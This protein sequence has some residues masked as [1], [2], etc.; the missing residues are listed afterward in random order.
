MRASPLKRLWAIPLI[1]LPAITALWI[2]VATRDWEHGWRQFQLG[3]HVNFPPRAKPGPRPEAIQTAQH[4]AGAVLHIAELATFAIAVVALVVLASRAH[5]RARR[6]RAIERWELRLGRDD[7]ANPYRVQ[8]AFEGIA[9]AIGVRWYERLCRGPQH[10]A[11]EVHRLHDASIRFVIAAPDR[12]LAAISGALEDLY[13][14]V[15]LVGWDRWPEASRCVVRLKKRASF[16]LSIQTTR[17]YEHAFS[18]SLVALIDKGTGDLCVQLVLAPASGHLHRRAR[19]L[20]KR[21]ERSLQHADH[22]DPGE[23]GIDSVIEAKELKGALE[24]QHRTLYQFD[25]RVSGEDPAS[26]RRVAGLF[27]Q[28][29]SENELVRRQMRMRRS[30]YAARIA[31]AMPNALPG[32]RTGTLSTSELATLWQLPRGRVKH[33]ALLRSTVRRASAPAEIDRDSARALMQDEHGG[34]TIAPADRKFGHALIGGQGGGKSSVMARHFANDTRDLERAVI[35]IDPKNSLA[36]LCLGLAPVDRVVHYMDLGHPEV[37]INPLTITASPG[38]RAAVFLQALIEANPAGAIQAASDSFLRQAVAAVCTVEAQPTLWHVYRMLDFGD[39]PYRRAVVR[40]LDRIPGADFARRYWRRDFPALIADRGYAAQALNPSRNKLERLISTREIDTVLRHPVT[41]D[42][43]GILERGEVLIVSGAKATVGED[44][45]ILVTQ[46]LLQLLHRAVQAQQGLP[47]R[48]RRRVSLLIDEAHNVLTPSV[49]KMLA[50]GRSAGLEAVFAWQYSAQIPD[51]VI[52]SG[53]RSLLQSISIFRMREM[54]DARSLAGLAMEVYS[55]H[56]GVDQ[57]EQERLR[58]APDDI[59]KLPIHRAINLWVADGVPRAGF[60][61]RTLPMEGLRDDDLAE[62]HLCAQRDRGAHEPGPLGDPLAQLDLREEAAP[63][64]ESSTSSDNASGH[65][66]NGRGPR[67]SDEQL[68]M[69]VDPPESS[70]EP[71]EPAR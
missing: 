71:E 24:T 61:A 4:V 39:S 27:S 10:I 54:E 13:P 22:R 41:L 7:L 29:R 12:L 44:N 26:V 34:V 6:A 33:G 2:F 58:F 14:D 51:E 57:D 23:L 69:P 17:N 67:Q 25:L 16:V 3:H 8:E 66:S 21:R 70:D 31:D 28:L 47:E 64:P 48:Q 37:G 52:R 1:W 35:L 55:D 32:L 5:H 45:T 63:Q 65:R 38:A 62:R 50:E 9:G 59:V 49:A 43:E 18:E 15:E 46:L 53:V 42:L 30:L 36:E 19:R 40:R 60:L 11:F 20:L 68:R 56:I